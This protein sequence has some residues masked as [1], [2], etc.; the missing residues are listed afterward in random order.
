MLLKWQSSLNDNHVILEVYF[1]ALN[2]LNLNLC[3]KILYVEVLDDMGATLQR[4]E[5]AELWQ[6]VFILM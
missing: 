3:V 4:K 2:L 1:I 5:K 6:Q